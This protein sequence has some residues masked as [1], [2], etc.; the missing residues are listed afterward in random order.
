[1]EPKKLYRSRTN[2]MIAGIC[3]GFAEFLGLDPTV[4]RLL[5]LLLTFITAGTALIFYFIAI[6]VIPQE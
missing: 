4:V 2:T 3:G 6:F 5:Y 1:M